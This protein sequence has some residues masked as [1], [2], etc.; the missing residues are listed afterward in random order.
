ETP[1]VSRGEKNITITTEAFDVIEGLSVNSPPR[2]TFIK[3][4][5]SFSE[6]SNEIDLFAGATN[7]VFCNATIIDFD[8]EE[9]FLFNSVK[10]YHNTSSFF[11]L[12]AKRNHYTNESCFIDKSFGDENEI[13]VSCKFEVF[14]Y[15]SPGEWFCNFSFSDFS[16]KNFSFWNTTK[17]NELLAIEV[18][19]TLNYGPL[20][21]DTISNEKILNITNLGNVEINLSLYGYAE[22]PEDGFSFKCTNGATIPIYEQKYNLTD[23]NPSINTKEELNEKYINLTSSIK[24]KKFEL[25]PRELDDI[26]DAIKPTFWRVYVPPL[27][28][29]TCT[30]NIVFGAVYSPEN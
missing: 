8:G 28:S 27:I 24:I 6:P 2:I 18:E 19:N 29:G 15:A 5:D 13:F 9:D 22:T 11:S 4:D 20:I 25:S 12:D 16:L 23:S 26:N 14:Y 3:I 30:G 7:F 17:V 1:Y 10:F 21:A